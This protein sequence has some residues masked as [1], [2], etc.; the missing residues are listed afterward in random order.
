MCNVAN[1]RLLKN[2][3]GRYFGRYNAVW[4]IFGQYFVDIWLIL[5]WSISITTPLAALQKDN[6]FVFFVS[7]H[8]IILYEIELYHMVLHS[9]ASN[10]IVF[11]WYCMVSYGV[12]W[13]CIIGSGARAGDSY[14]DESWNFNFYMVSKCS[15]LFILFILFRTVFVFVL[16]PFLPLSVNFLDF[17]GNFN[18]KMA[19]NLFWQ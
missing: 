4:S 9:F 8:C 3:C 16:R 18:G 12:A 13:Y 14:F 2:F 15:I 10:C 6:I 5:S 1:T 17:N 19:K 7:W 11:V